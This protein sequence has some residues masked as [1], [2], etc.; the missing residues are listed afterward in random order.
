MRK[1]YGGE[2]N[3]KT[4]EAS[5]VYPFG[6]GSRFGRKYDLAIMMKSGI[7]DTQDASQVLLGEFNIQQDVKM[8]IQLHDY[9]DFRVLSWRTGGF[10]GD[11]EPSL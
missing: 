3:Y 11:F 2:V 9:G 1:I 5:P 7:G 6:K 10:G 8:Y 4:E